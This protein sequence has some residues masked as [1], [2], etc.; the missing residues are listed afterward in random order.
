M[1]LFRLVFDSYLLWRSFTV[2][3]SALTFSCTN[4]HVDAFQTIKGIAAKE[5]AVHH[6]LNAC[7]HIGLAHG[8]FGNTDKYLYLSTVLY[9][10][11]R[12][13]PIRSA[14]PVVENWIGYFGA[15]P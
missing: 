6:V 10:Q 4:F 8:D 2:F 15:V 1:V 13:D 9:A 3:C 11:W 12:C 5:V 7:I 14:R